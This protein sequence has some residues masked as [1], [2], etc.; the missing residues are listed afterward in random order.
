MEEFSKYQDVLGQMTFLKTYTHICL[1][2]PVAGNTSKPGIVDELKRASYHLTDAF[3]WIAGHVVRKGSGPGKTGLATIVPYKEGEG[4]PTLITVKDCGEQC[5][6]FDEIVK[7]G[8]PMSMLDGEILAVRKALPDGYDES[9]EPAPVIVIQANFIKGGL[10]LAIMGNHN[11]MDMNGMGHMIH[12]FASAIRG[13]PFSETEIEQGNRDKRDVIK[14]LGMD[15]EKVDISHF[16][17]KPPPEDAPTGVAPQPEPQWVYFH[18]PG[19]KLA[20]LKAIASTPAGKETSQWASTDDVL[21]A[22]LCQH[23]TTARLKRLPKKPDSTVTFCRAINVR[24]FL[25]PPLP[26]EYPGHMVYCLNLKVPLDSRTATQDL[27]ALAQQLRADLRSLKSVEIQ[28]FATALNAED[29]KGAIS[30]AANLDT[31][32]YDMIFSSFS[33][34]GLYQTDFGKMLG[35]KPVF[36]KRQRFTPIE[37]LLYLMPRTDAGDVDVAC[38]LRSDDID[39]LRHDEEFLKY[40]KYIG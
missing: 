12:L 14:L 21:S 10:L 36:A 40:A 31:T 37:S 16:R 22:F 11:I 2:F 20:E 34:L 29:D 33:G 13:E 27:A 25:E 26:N 35:G 38:C 19:A 9:V 1:G 39:S 28:S 6:S 4:P 24:R 5:P 17:V 30:F 15:D 23:I 32:G 3:P 8:A 18:F 7:A